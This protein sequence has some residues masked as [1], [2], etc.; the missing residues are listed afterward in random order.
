MV[1]ATNK[2]ALVN[3]AINGKKSVEAKINIYT[4]NN[5]IIKHIK[6]NLTYIYSTFTRLFW[7][8][9]R[10]LMASVTF[11]IMDWIFSVY[12]SRCHVR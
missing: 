9:I 5:K 1:C 12:L 6:S 2:D 3:H 8:L 7:R 11:A 10:L 4:I